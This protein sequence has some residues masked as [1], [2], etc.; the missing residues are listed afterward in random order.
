MK[1]EDKVK[2]WEYHE[3]NMKPKMIAKELGYSVSTIK[4]VIEEYQDI[5]DIQLERE[6]DL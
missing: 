4:R 3:A 1:D 5:K 6:E 2:L